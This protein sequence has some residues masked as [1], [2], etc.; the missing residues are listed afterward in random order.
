MQGYSGWAIM[1]SLTRG[2]DARGTRLQKGTLRRVLGYVHRY[3]AKLVFF[4]VSVVILAVLGAIPPLLLRALLDTAIPEGNRRLVVVLATVTLGIALADAALNIVQRWFSAAIGEGLIYD[5]RVELYDHMQRMPI[6]FFTRTQTGALVSRLNNDVVGAQRAVTTTVSQILSNFISVAVTLTVMFALAWQVTLLAL[7]VLPIFIVSARWVGRRLQRITRDS[8]NHNAAMNTLMTERFNVSGAMLVKLF[9]RQGSDSDEFGRR[10][11][12]VRDIGVVSAMY[13]RTFMVTLGFVAAIATAG[14]YL[15]GG[16]SAVEGAMEVGTIAALSLYLAQLYTPLT[17]LTTARVDY[18]AAM[19]SFE[20]V[21]EVLDLETAIEDR[22][23]AL[24]LTGVAGR[25]RLED[26]SFHYPA[27]A[28]M[29]LES[30]KEIGPES[31]A[32]ITKTVLSHVDFEVLPGELVALVGPSGAGKT[33]IAQLVPRLYD[34]VEGAV[35]IDGHDVRDITLQ[36]LSDAIGIVTQDPHL[37]HESIADNLRFAK[38]DAT[39]AELE[40]ACRKAN[41]HDVVAALPDAY[42]TVVGERGYRLSGG[43]KQRLALARML[44][45]DPRIV[46]LDEATSHLDSENEAAIQRALEESLEG[47]SSLVI[48]HRLS[49]IVGADRILVVDGGRIVEAGRHEELLARGGLYADL[50]ETQFAGQAVS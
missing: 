34:V 36:S 2:A 33:T 37:F 23:G 48:A 35:L 12:H 8:M 26:V 6:A 4:V 18:L 28:G 46:I 41:V 40:A 50:Y 42:E 21:F 27:G 13:T 11:A 30:L 5:L 19:V 3:K 49:T 25:I 14:L 43:E 17:A 16:L 47:R 1:H 9:G 29:L 20:R 32:D 44:L 7:L 10:A 38:P 22:H 39:Q 45:K 15:F 24:P 31:E